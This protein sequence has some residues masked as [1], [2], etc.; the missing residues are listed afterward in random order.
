[1]SSGARHE[2]LFGT[3]KTTERQRR[4]KCAIRPGSCA[5]LHQRVLAEQIQASPNENR[6]A[7]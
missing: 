4:L 6:A 2:L 3:R 1:M 7:Q 5:R